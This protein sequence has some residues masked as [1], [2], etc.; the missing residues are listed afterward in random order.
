MTD[1]TSQV[2]AAYDQL[3]H[4]YASRNH[5]VMPENVLRLAQQLM[6]YV[7]AGAHV[8]DVGCGT[9]RDMAW[10]ESQGLVVTGIDLSTEMLAFARQSVRGNLLSAN[11]CRLGFREGSFDAAWCC[12][13]L[14]HVPKHDAGAALREIRRVL[15]EGGMLALSLQ[16]GSGEGW[17]EGY[18]PDVRR[19]FA[20][21]S[22]EE[23]RLVLDE[24]GFAVSQ[25]DVVPDDGRAWLSCICI[26]H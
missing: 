2:R 6:Q 5:T 16:E 10:F 22:A 4:A 7:G 23:L 24:A 8:V 15:K 9:G 19:Y 21:Y 14:L 13:S 26:A 18:V 11:M 25:I 12:A 17:E 20:R 1:V 3:V